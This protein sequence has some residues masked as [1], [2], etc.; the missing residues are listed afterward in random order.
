M[1][2]KEPLLPE[3][4]SVTHLQLSK[5]SRVKLKGTKHD[6]GGEHSREL[7]ILCQS[8]QSDPRTTT[9]VSWTLIIAA[10]TRRPPG[11]FRSSPSLEY[12]HWILHLSASASVSSSFIRFNHTLQPT[13]TFSLQLPSVLPP[14][15]STTHYS[16]PIY[17]EQWQTS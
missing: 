1:H 2:H 6:F 10:S 3:P 12:K 5:I 14:A 15:T 7:W 17:S 11:A 16:L 13:K 4:R 8:P 9:Y